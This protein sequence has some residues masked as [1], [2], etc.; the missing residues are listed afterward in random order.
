MSA[1]P[2]RG[3]RVPLPLLTSSPIAVVSNDL[4]EP[5]LIERR[6]R[7]VKKG[8]LCSSQTFVTK[9]QRETTDDE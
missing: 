9:V 1:A 8:A 5:T 2:D 3:Q 4:D 6:P 7:E